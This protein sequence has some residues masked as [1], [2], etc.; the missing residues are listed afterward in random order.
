MVLA[1]F[2]HRLHRIHR[3]SFRRG[4]LSIRCFGRGDYRSS[5]EFDFAASFQKADFELIYFAGRGGGMADAI[6]SK[7]IDLTVMR[8]RL[9]PAAPKN[10]TSALSAFL[11]YML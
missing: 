9:S 4:P 11:F 5:D 1:I 7:S 8:V 6:D 3:P 10:S 2:Y